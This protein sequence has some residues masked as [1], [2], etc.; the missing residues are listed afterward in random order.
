[1]TNTMI[2]GTHPREPPPWRDRVGGTLVIGR[3]A[4]GVAAR[5]A[6]AVNGSR[7]LPSGD[8]SC[9]PLTPSGWQHYR[10]QAKRHRADG[11]AILVLRGLAGT[12]ATSDATMR[13][14]LTYPLNRKGPRARD[15]NAR[16]PGQSSRGWQ[17]LIRPSTLTGILRHDERPPCL[18]ASSARCVVPFLTGI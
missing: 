18:L 3:V 2:I 7:G 5:I 11:G 16:R 15:V 1:M 17:P 4:S 13:F 14:C 6:A 10:R 9:S 8:P 12:W